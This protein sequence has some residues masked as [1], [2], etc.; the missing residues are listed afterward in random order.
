MTTTYALRTMVIEHL[1]A[2]PTIFVNPEVLIKLDMGEPKENR[3]WYAPVALQMRQAEPRAYIIIPTA[4]MKMVRATKRVM[5][6]APHQEAIEN[7]LNLTSR[8]AGDTWDVL[9]FWVFH[10]DGA[11]I[12]ALKEMSHVPMPIRFTPLSACLPGSVNPWA[13]QHAA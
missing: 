7:C 2:D 10:P 8:I 13:H 12:E 5:Q 1:T 6:M 11:D 4:D 3:H 9:H